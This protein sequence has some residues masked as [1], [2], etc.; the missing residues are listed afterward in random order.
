MIKV[1]RTQPPSILN[2]LGAKWLGELQEAIKQLEIIKK[3]S[4]ITETNLR[5]AKRSVKNAQK[6]YNH[7]N[8]KKALV[9][10]FNGKCAYCESK[11]THITYGHIEHFYPKGNPK[12]TYKTFEWENLLL[13]CNICNNKSHKGEKFPLDAN[14][15]PLLINPTD[16][17]THPN[18]HLKFLWDFRTHLASIYGRDIRGKTVEDIFDLNG[19]KGRKEL[20]KERSGYVKKLIVLLEFAKRGDAEALEILKDAC[21][22]DAPYTAFA[23]TYVAPYIESL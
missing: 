12:Y 22:T 15:N 5:T 6:K 20:I 11:I 19:L 21:K 7:P 16:E 8:I 13:A 9:K 10:M 2:Q 18:K 4:Q 3:D 23:L 14:G 17:N 1:I